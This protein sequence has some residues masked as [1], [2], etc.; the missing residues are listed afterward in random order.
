MDESAAE[1]VSV[2]QMS[3]E[4]GGDKEFDFVVFGASGFTGQ[5]VVEEVART[6]GEEDQGLKWAV[7]G[8]SMAKVQAV[9][10]TASNYTGIHHCINDNM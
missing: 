5:Y 6:I 10:Q 3:G 7:A 1:S 4:S 2:E 8:R 9:L